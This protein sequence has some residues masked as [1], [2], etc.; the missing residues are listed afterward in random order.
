MTKDPITGNVSGQSRPNQVGLAHEMIHG[1]RSMRG[2][3]IDY[4]KWGTQTYKDS[5]GKTVTEPVRMEEAAT[6]GV[7][8]HTKKEITENHIRKEQGQNERGA[9]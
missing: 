3:A 2:Q 1:E 8:Y 4:D 5:S 9:Y 7:K 6:S